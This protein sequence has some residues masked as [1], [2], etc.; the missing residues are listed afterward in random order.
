MIL[1]SISIITASE[2][3][4]LSDSPQLHKKN[5]NHHL[6]MRLKK[7]LSLLN[8]IPKNL[9]PFDH[10]TRASL[11]IKTI[12]LNRSIHSSML[13]KSLNPLIGCWY[14]IINGSINTDQLFFREFSVIICTLLMYIKKHID[15]RIDQK[16]HTIMSITQKIDRLPI[17]EILNTIDMLTHELPD[18]L[19]RYE[20]NSTITWKKWLKKYWWIPPVVIFW[21]GLKVLVKFQ[22]RPGYIVNY[23]PGSSP[24]PIVTNDPALLEIMR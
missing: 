4:T 9:I 10:I 11:P 14:A 3:I 8:S 16:A 19:E 20:F 12:I 22:N 23:Y 13:N 7:A 24:A 15:Q 1:I 6:I 17:M 21:F 5:L 18:F 2:L